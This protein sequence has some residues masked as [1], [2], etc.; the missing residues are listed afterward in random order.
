MKTTPTI[1]KDALDQFG[2][3]LNQF[4]ASGDWPEMIPKTASILQEIVDSLSSEDAETALSSIDHHLEYNPSEF[5]FEF[6]TDHVGPC[7]DSKY[8]CTLE[9][10][11]KKH[12][13]VITVAS[14]R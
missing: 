8:S 6:K 14:R 11:D 5:K 4:I 7:H 10:G 3:D 12:P 1:T 13:Y 9:I 2:S